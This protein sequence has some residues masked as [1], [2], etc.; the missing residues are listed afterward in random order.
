MS[1]TNCVP[2]EVLEHLKN[3]YNNQKGQKYPCSNQRVC[4][5]IVTNDKEK[6]MKFMENKSI[7]EKR[8][9][10]SG[11]V[12]EW[13]LENGEVWIWRIW[14]ETLR[15]YRFY[16]IAVD[17]KIDSDLFETVV[18]PLCSFYCCSFEVI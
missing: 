11:K 17:K 9:Y 7:V 14:N 4:C 12:I 8:Q 3:Y 6:A 15:G 5:G 16:K 1:S 13:F 2:I 18:I 10:D